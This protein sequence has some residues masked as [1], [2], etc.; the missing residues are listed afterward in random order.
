MT[1]NKNIEWSETTETT[2]GFLKVTKVSFP[3]YTH[4]FTLQLAGSDAP[5]IEVAATP[6]ELVREFA[7]I[8]KWLG[9]SV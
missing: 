3:N 7:A 2:F 9:G 8:A 1:L 4:A 5:G 6:E